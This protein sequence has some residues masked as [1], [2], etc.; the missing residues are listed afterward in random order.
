MTDKD[1]YWSADGETFNYDTLGEMLDCNDL[2][3]G[4]TV[5]GITPDPA[6]WVSADEGSEG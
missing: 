6:I 3:A 4:D 2:Q 1:E 5:S